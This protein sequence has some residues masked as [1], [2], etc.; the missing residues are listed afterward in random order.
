MGLLTH[1][2][3]SELRS[4]SFEMR[5]ISLNVSMY[6]QKIRDGCILYPTSTYSTIVFPSK[7]KLWEWTTHINQIFGVNACPNTALIDSQTDY[8]AEISQRVI[9]D[10]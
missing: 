7:C 4:Q 5:G 8:I 2:F 6:S 9:F 3:S 1:V 10:T